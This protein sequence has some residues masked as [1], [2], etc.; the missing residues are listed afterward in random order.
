MK[1]AR[2]RDLPG[3]NPHPGRV[4]IDGGGSFQN[5][6]ADEGRE[7]RRPVFCFLVEDLAEEP[8][9]IFG[10][11]PAA[12]IPKILP[13]MRCERRELLHVCSGALPKGEGIRIDVRPDA[14]PD[15]VADGRAMPFEDGSMAAA[16]IDPPYTEH[17]ARHLYG[18]SYPRPIDLLRE[19][20][21]VVRPNGR[22]A[23]VHYL[24]PNPPKGAVF[25]KCFGLS[26]GFGYPL[27]AV[28]IFEKQQG[29]LF[30]GEHPPPNDRAARRVRRGK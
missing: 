25:V 16:L 5:R 18:T 15:H 29:T 12:F 4:Q 17:Y 11:Y 3:T 14:R 10:M 28:T 24:V 21:R 6:P 19:A 22:I 7:I 27:R 20:V 30:A 2:D 8:S 26:T 1:H 23:L 13:W 9:G